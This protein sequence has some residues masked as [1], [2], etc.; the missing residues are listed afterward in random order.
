MDAWWSWMCFIQRAL[1]FHKTAMIMQNFIYR[2]HA[3]LIFSPCLNNTSMN[4]LN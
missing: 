1:K 4:T 3:I 2:A